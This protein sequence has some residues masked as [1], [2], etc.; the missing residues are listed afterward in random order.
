[1]RCSIVILKNIQKIYPNGFHAL[2]KINLS[3]DKGDIYGIIGFS[4]AGKS[5]LI[6][7]INLLEQPTSGSIIVD[8]K[9]IN[10]LTAKELRFER[11][12]I[13]MI[14]QHFNLLSSRNVYGNIAFALEIAKWHKSSIKNRVEE[15][16]ELVDLRDKINYYPSQLSGGQKQRVAIA[17]A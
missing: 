14:F 16:L 15:L 11:Q 17:R 5:S 8:G 10:K 3:V 6:R 2:K 7:L 9:E 4:G 1:M 12:K 13:G